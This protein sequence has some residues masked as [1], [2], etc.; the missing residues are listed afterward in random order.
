[1]VHRLEMTGSIMNNNKYC[2][3]THCN[4]DKNKCILFNK[5]NTITVVIHLTDKCNSNCS[6]CW[7]KDRIHS[8][9]NTVTNQSVDKLIR[10]IKMNYDID[11]LV[12][13]FM[14]GEPTTSMDII[15][16]TV[17]KVADNFKYSKFT[18]ITNGVEY[19]GDNEFI[20][21]N[22]ITIQMSIPWT[23]VDNY[24]IRM[25][26]YKKYVE[27]NDYYGNIFT[28]TQVI[29]DNDI[30]HD[31]NL[32]KKINILDRRIKC[33][34]L[35]EYDPY[36]PKYHDVS[37]DDLR[38]TLITIHKSGFHNIIDMNKTDYILDSD[39]SQMKFFT[40]FNDGK[41]YLNTRFRYLKDDYSIGNIDDGINVNKI[42]DF[43]KSIPCHTCEF[44][45]YCSV[46][47]VCMIHGINGECELTKQLI[48]I[49]TEL[50]NK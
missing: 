14:G 45:D 23:N 40:Y 42:S 47:R 49:K 35:I 38:R 29:D 33:Q 43:Y 34:F 25:E 8:S 2:N 20:L 24:D 44:R 11:G 17:N 5:A 10:F 46:D 9:T 19:I 32:R 18:I 4:F 41:I 1:M 21:N 6:F 26:N 36:D 30:R 22:N 31:E 27:L 39:L 15:E 16:Y 7:H 3:L 37:Y 13:V 28:T 48:K 50:S 12:I